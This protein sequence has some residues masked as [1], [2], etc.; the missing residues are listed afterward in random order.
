MTGLQIPGLSKRDYTQIFQQIDLD[1]NR[2]L[3][4]NEFALY[5]EGAQKSRDERIRDIPQEMLD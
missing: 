2:F 3:S 4:V 1:G 5:L